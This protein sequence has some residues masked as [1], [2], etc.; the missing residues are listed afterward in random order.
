MIPKRKRLLAD[1]PLQEKKA[2][3]ESATAIPESY[4]FT[5]VAKN[6]G[7]KNPIPSLLPTE[8][9]LNDILAPLSSC[10][11]TM[12]ALRQ[13]C[14]G[15]M[16]AAS[17][18][19]RN[20]V[21]Y[22]PDPALEVFWDQHPQWPFRI[23][24]AQYPAWES[25]C[26]YLLPYLEKSRFATCITK[27]SISDLPTRGLIELCANPSFRL[28]EL[29][30]AGGCRSLSEAEPFFFPTTLTRISF[31]HLCG[32]SDKDFSVLLG[33]L[34]KSLKSLQFDH[35]SHL[36]NWRNTNDHIPVQ[37][38]DVPS[39]LTQ[40]NLTCSDSLVPNMNPSAS[41][42]SDLNLSHTLPNR[43]NQSA[44]T[45]MHS[46][47]RLDL[48][49]C[50]VSDGFVEQLPSSLTSLDLAGAILTDKVLHSLSQKL[51]KLILC[52]CYYISNNG[53]AHLVRLSSLT[54]L[55]LSYCTQ[56]TDCAL[57][58]LPSNIRSMYLEGCRKITDAGV[59]YLQPLMMDALNLNN[60]S[61]SHEVFP[62]LSSTL[63]KLQCFSCLWVTDLRQMPLS[64]TSLD[65]RNCNF[66]QKTVYEKQNPFFHP[67]AWHHIPPNLT[68]LR[69][70]T[71]NI[72]D[73][74]L[75]YIPS[76]VTFLD[77]SG[78]TT[79]TGS[80]FA[81]FP[82][83]LTILNLSCCDR[84]EKWDFN[85]LTNLR[86][87]NLRDSPSLDETVTNLPRTLT[88]LDLS[89]RTSRITNDSIFYDLPP[90]ITHLYIGQCPLLSSSA[91]SKEHLKRVLPRI[92]LII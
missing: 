25:S 83:S 5:F 81:H 78:C 87:L 42:L 53:L 61:I 40:L 56:I 22:L 38:F 21:H 68:E 26:R 70:T 59:H 16:Y 89:S 17:Q 27:M 91:A 86:T 15:F 71:S 72:T 54:E 67:V 41:S 80:G 92:N 12:S 8:V 74:D 88:Q 45:H 2:E 85:H 63:K 10:K 65:L 57:R 48:S 77:L 6:P 4:D 75:Q 24:A 3:E 82:P 90:G 7:S 31:S 44:I 1:I 64:L 9:W 36:P 34:P 20:Q 43:Q 46:L 51:T 35:Y 30:I 76:R 19:W 62:V 73:S 69:I 33:N 79:I 47:T 52:H 66:A 39:N 14:R 13:S 55:D 28:L 50:R 58:T 23:R 32:L 11:Y 18:I 84:L 29:E 60:T 49:F 37:K